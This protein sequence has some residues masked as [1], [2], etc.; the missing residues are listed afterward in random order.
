M[1]KQEEIENELSVAI[2]DWLEKNTSPNRRS[3]HFQYSIAL[4]YAVAKVLAE[5]LPENHTNPKE[6]NDDQRKIL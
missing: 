1:T 3:C 6:E 5:R 2:G 4:K